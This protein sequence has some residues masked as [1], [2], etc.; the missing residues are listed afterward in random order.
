M[1][2]STFVFGAFMFNNQ[3]DL[4]GVFDGHNGSAAAEFAALNIPRL[5]EK[6]LKKDPDDAPLALFQV[7]PRHLPPI[8][9]HPQS[10]EDLNSMLKD[11]AIG[12][13]STALVALAGP[14][15][16][17]FANLGDSRSAHSSSLPDHAHYLRAVMVAS[18]KAVRITTDH[19]PD[20]AEEKKRIEEAGGQVVVRTA[21]DGTPHSL[22]PRPDSSISL[23]Q[24]VASYQWDSRRVSIT[25]RL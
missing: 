13:G 10:F 9:D 17:H 22:L 7:L 3:L 20:N 15:A 8:A 11:K 2:D 19:R 25:G 14:N 4:L 6:N 21:R 18:G 24:G 23:R 12:G 16:V 5:V 1:E